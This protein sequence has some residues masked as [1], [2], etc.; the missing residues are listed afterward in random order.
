[1]SEHPVWDWRRTAGVEC[2]QEERQKYEGEARTDATTASRKERFYE[3]EAK[4]CLSL[5]IWN[6]VGKRVLDFEAEHY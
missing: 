6:R 1:M 5:E 4:R 2:Y 3:R